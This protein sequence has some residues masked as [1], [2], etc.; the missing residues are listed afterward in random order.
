MSTS[1]SLSEIIELDA[2]SPH[3]RPVARNS[4]CNSSSEAFREKL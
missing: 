3:S 4:I 1:L 2:Q